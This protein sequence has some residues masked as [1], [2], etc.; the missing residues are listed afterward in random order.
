MNIHSVKTRLVG[1]YVLLLILFFIQIPIIYTLIG[2]MGKKYTQ[3]VEVVSLRKRAIELRYVL[4]RH[5]MNGEEELEAV[6]QAKKKEFTSTLGLLRTGSDGFEGITDPE[7][8]Q[9]LD[10]VVTHWKPMN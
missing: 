6:F 8:L 10:V 1:S 7:V 3:I 9:K 2:G 4:N 5:I